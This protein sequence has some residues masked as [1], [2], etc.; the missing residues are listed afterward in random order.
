MRNLLIIVLLCLL[1]G[2]GACSRR[3]NSS[4]IDTSGSGGDSLADNGTQARTQL[5]NGREFYRK[6]QDEKAIEAFQQA[7][8]LDSDLAEA[9]FR[10]GLTYDAIGREQEAAES[11][12]NAV[13]SYKK[14]FSVPE[15]DNDAEA[16]YNLAQTYA[17]LSLYTEAVRE[18]R[19][20]TR[21]KNDDADMFYDMGL[22]LA[23]LAQY[24]EAA[25][26]FSKS[27]EID[28][29]NYRAEDELEEAR[30]GVKRIKAGKKH[31]EALLKKKKEE[32]LKKEQEGPTPDTRTSP[33]DSK[34]PQ[35]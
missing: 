15:N 24:D 16:H 27:L 9:H 28:P 19:V 5:E 34:Q 1:V 25:A 23:R 26:A 6:D 8:K 29:E 18:Y 13:R 10:L 21:L 11:Y 22:A 4:Q 20:A 31:Q 7:I 17:G 14:Y 35:A 3:N 12:K 30:E 33:A 32:E 2:Q